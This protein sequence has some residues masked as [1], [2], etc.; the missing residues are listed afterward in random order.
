MPS[1]HIPIPLSVGRVH[2]TRTLAKY[3]FGMQATQAVVPPLSLRH[4]YTVMGLPDMWN[5]ENDVEQV[6]NA[7]RN[8]RQ[9]SL[10]L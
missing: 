8:E 1:V 5:S 3:L 9:G 10:S 2:T 7:A 6:Y 4:Q